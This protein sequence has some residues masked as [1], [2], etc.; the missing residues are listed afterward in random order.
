MTSHKCVDCERGLSTNHFG[1]T[2]SKEEMLR[3][4]RRKT[5]L[6]DYFR[7]AGILQKLK[8]DDAEIALI[9]GVILLSAG[10]YIMNFMWFIKFIKYYFAITWHFTSVLINTCTRSYTL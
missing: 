10:T 5:F 2:Q 3:F 8:P 9:M 6:D 7:M 1:E 4:G